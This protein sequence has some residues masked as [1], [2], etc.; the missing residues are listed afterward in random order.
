V[1]PAVAG[2]DRP[3]VWVA[4]DPSVAGAAIGAGAADA[5]AWRPGDDL[6]LLAAKLDRLATPDDEGASDETTPD[7]EA[8]PDDGE[9]AD[10]GSPVALA[11]GSADGVDDVVH[12]AALY[13]YL[14]RTVGDAVYIL[15]EEG[16]FTFVNDAL[17]E[18]TGY[19]RDG[20]LGASVH[21]IKDDETVAEAEDALRRL[22]REY[23]ESGGDE[24]SIAELD[25]ELVRKD[26]RR[27]PCAD[28]MTLR[29]HE[30][31]SFSGT[32]GTLRDVSRQRRRERILNNLLRATQGMVGE[33]TTEGVA[34]R[35]VDVAMNT[36]D[37]EGAVVREYDPET[38]ELVP[39]AVPGAVRD[40]IG[41]RPRSDA[42]EGPVGT[43]FTENRT[44]RAENLYHTEAGPDEAGTYLPVGDDRTLSVGHD[45]GGEFMADA[46]QFLE[47]L[48]T[49]AGSV[50]DRVE[51]DQ[52]RRRYRAAVEA[53]ERGD[54]K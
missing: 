38:D 14:V 39:V 10:G 19:E 4:P 42:D 40:R 1:D 5:V 53:F 34:E 7:G 11:R 2:A 54:Y 13:E 25:V 35:V 9:T 15:D 37:A 27:I 20:L 12:D 50:F 28:R 22:L 48:A 8:T 26:G 41:E 43:A 47:L 31:G 36:I 30:D 16:R 29:P 33:A 46:R 24:L 49:T 3:V 44:V 18:M 51:Q 52:E 17:C 6:G 23:G 21:R 45:G 32:V